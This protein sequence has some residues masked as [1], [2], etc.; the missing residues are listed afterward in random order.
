MPQ[1]AEVPVSE[2]IGFE[3]RI[4]AAVG[5]D[6]AVLN[7]DYVYTEGEGDN[8]LET[9]LQ[10]TTDGEVDCGDDIHLEVDL[11]EDSDTNETNFDIIDDRLDDRV[12]VQNAMAIEALMQRTYG[13]LA[14]PATREY[15]TVL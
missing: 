15:A 8:W 12:D 13:S 2:T 9:A 3:Y 14:L 6:E 5:V 11:P 1:P 7:D 4:P 10:D